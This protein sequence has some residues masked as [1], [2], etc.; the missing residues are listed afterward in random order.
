[1]KPN[2]GC[3]PLV[4]T[5]PRERVCK[6]VSQKSSSHVAS[7][8]HNFCVQYLIHV[9]VRQHAR[10]SPRTFHCFL[11]N[12]SGTPETKPPSSYSSLSACPGG[13]KARSLSKKAKALLY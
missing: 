4:K 6:P 1:M 10:A 5:L 7:S 3:W 9:A 12:Q 13:K 2:L 8:N 11:I